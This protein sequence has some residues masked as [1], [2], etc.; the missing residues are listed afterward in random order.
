MEAK[1]VMD[2]IFRE[3][4]EYGESIVI[5]DQMPSTLMDSAIANTATQITLCLKHS[6]D[7]RAAGN[8]MLLDHDEKLFLGKLPVGTAIVKLQNRWHAPFIL[9]LP[10]VAIKAGK[11]P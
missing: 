4:R 9:R 11:N 10:Y 1:S 3:I 8:A 2:R 7:V 6:D 5:I